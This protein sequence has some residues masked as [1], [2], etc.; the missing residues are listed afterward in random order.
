M[1]QITQITLIGF[2]A[3]IIGT[4]SGSIIALFIKNPPR[5]MMSFFLGFAGGI[6]LAI[7]LI[8]LLPEAIESGNFL[9]AVLGLSLGAL[10]LMI[11][12]TNIPHLHLFEVK[13]GN[14]DFIRSGVFLGIGIAL[15]NL[16]EGLAIGAGYMASPSL[17]LSLAITIALHNIPEGLAMAC[18][19]CVGGMKV[20]RIF[21]VTALAG[22][23]MGVGAF[24]GSALGIVSPLFLSLALSFAG[25]AMLYIIFNELIPGAH[26][27][28]VGQ[29]GTIG[30]VFGIIAGVILLAII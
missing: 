3:G 11:I 24:L 15:H 2:L 16:P 20:A 10:I 23:P 8:D 9:I 29:S 21:A 17:G 13:S 6:M 26:K 12:D 7:V 25:G 30:A 5:K 28:K 4:G 1:N 18:P 14:N 22:L 19:L 27:L